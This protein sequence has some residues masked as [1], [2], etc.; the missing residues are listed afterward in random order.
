MENEQVCIKNWNVKGFSEGWFYKTK[1][2]NL[3]IMLFKS[4]SPVDL[5]RLRRQGF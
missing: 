4:S 3:T 1:T 2:G 5:K